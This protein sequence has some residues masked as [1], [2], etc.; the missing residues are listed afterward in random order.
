M[1]PP[2]LQS[3]HIR[4]LLP[5]LASAGCLLLWFWSHQ[6]LE[7]IQ[8]RH[9]QL[10]RQHQTVSQQVKLLH[11][12]QAY[13]Q[14][15][16]DDIARLQEQGLL[17]VASTERWLEALL[18]SGQPMGITRFDA[19]RIKPIAQDQPSFPPQLRV[20]QRHQLEFS[21][22]DLHEVELLKLLRGYRQQLG[23][24]FRLQACE[25]THPSGQG[26]SARCQLQFF[27]LPV[28]KQAAP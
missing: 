13:L 12:N 24:N 20:L 1:K 17:T 21:V 25:L 22:H 18:A 4:L 5:L 2:W 10:T 9:H 26:L 7:Q 14:Q 19:Y 11:D 28:K 27:S 6:R 15:H 16:Q 3:V 23:N 8:S